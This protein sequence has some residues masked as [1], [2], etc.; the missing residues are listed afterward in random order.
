MSIPAAL[1][2]NY[3][4][5]VVLRFIQ[6]FLGSPILA[7]GGASAG[8]LFSFIKIPYAMS[9]WVAAA[10]AGPAFGPL[11][12]GFAVMYSTWRWSMYELIIIG[13]GILALMFFFLPETNPETILLRRAQRLR[14]RTGNST[15]KS[16]SEIKQ[17]RLHFGRVVL[18]SLM[19]PF[20]IITQD[21]A[22][23]FTNIYTSLTY[24]IYVSL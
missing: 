5:L 18:D 17:G 11:L 8:D 6:G 20:R 13:G 4:G 24:A 16:Q 19:V 2:N 22:V 7:T 23:L 15:L 1:V 3:P 21:P 9:F 14:K 12:S 10:Y